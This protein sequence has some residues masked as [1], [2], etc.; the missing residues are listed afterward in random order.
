[1]IARAYGHRVGKARGLLAL[2]PPEILEP[3]RSEFR[4]AHR[5]LDVFVAEVSL[6]RPSVVPSVRQRANYCGAV[7]S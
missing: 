6:Q 1:M 3:R 7:Y 5:V 4:I 2:G